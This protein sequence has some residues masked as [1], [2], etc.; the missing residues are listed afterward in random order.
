MLD[1]QNIAVECDKCAGW[2]VGMQDWALRMADDGTWGRGVVLDPHRSYEPQAACR[3]HRPQ[4]PTGARPWGTRS[5]VKTFEFGRATGPR[6]AREPRARRETA[7]R[8]KLPFQQSTRF[9]HLFDLQNVP[10][11]A[12]SSS[13]PGPPSNHLGRYHGIRILRWLNIPPTGLD[14]YVSD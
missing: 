11:Q 2:A 12:S 1:M 4:E 6:G 9:F 10:P 8:N 5:L 13:R 7:A 14:C 3:L